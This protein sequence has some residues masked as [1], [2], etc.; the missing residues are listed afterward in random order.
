MC[1]SVFLIG[2]K[3]RIS[4]QFYQSNPIQNKILRQQKSLK[5][6]IFTMTN[7]SL[8]FCR[9]VVRQNLITSNHSQTLEMPKCRQ[10]LENVAD[11]G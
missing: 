7:I 5:Y 1:L 8:L 9:Y 3:I 6:Y 10:A 4:S 11:F 2:F